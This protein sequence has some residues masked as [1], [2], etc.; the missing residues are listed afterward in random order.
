[1]NF[2][3]SILEESVKGQPL[4]PGHPGGVVAVEVN[5]DPGAGSTGGEVGGQGIELRLQLAGQ[6]LVVVIAEG[7]P[8]I[9]CSTDSAVAG[10]GQAR[11]AFVRGHDDRNTTAVILGAITSKR[12][13]GLGPVEYKNDL[14]WC[15]VTL[16]Q[17][18]VDGPAQQLRTVSGGD[19]NR[20]GP[21]GQMS[22]S[23]RSVDVFD[24]PFGAVSTI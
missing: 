11:A 2:G 9:G 8:G 10:S 20:N 4:R 18:P 12:Q 17:H 7:D 13:I 19:H 6:P 14:N 21:V 16:G 3:H 23:T 1:V 24:Y 5:Q 22:R 15:V